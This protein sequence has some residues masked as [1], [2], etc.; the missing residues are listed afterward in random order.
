MKILVGIFMLLMSFSARAENC[1]YSKA[2]GGASQDNQVV[3]T[4]GCNKKVCAAVAV[5]GDVVK[6]VICAQTSSGEC[7]APSACVAGSTSLN[8][9][10][11]FVATPYTE[12]DIVRPP[13]GGER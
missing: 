1:R 3:T 4:A 8:L 10:A 13:R 6:N 11:E 2:I 5:C 7:P 12:P 9:R